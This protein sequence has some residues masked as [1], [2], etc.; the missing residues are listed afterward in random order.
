VRSSLD[1]YTRGSVVNQEIE[2]F[3]V[4][5]DDFAQEVIDQLVCAASFRHFSR[6]E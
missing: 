3:L 6:S 4:F 5:L 1:S 2:F